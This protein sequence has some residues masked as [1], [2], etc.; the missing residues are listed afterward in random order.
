M[1]MNQKNEEEKRVKKCEGYLFLQ[2]PEYFRDAGIYNNQ[3]SRMK[4][5]AFNID[6]LGQQ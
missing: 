1:G 2:I 3:C 5:P 4:Q 6:C